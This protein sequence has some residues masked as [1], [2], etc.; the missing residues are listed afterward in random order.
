MRLLV[1]A[2]TGEA[3]A[4]CQRLAGDARVEVLASLAGETR[5]P[6]DLG[7]AVRRGGFGGGIAQE[8]FILDNEISAVIDATH[9]FAERISHRTHAICARLGLPCLRLIRPGW[10]AEDG[11]TWTVAGG[12]QWGSGR[13]GGTVRV[14]CGAGGEGLAGVV[15]VAGRGGVCGVID[16]REG[17]FR[18][19]GGGFVV[20]RPPFTVEGEV[21]LFTREGVDVLV[22]KDA[23]GEAGKAKLLAAR[24]LGIQVILIRRPPLPPG[25]RTGTVAGALDWLEGLL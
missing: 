13:V 22:A 17:P 11:G 25:A 15:N 23:G 14:F 18:L 20:G 10:Q 6:A 4:L 24:R 1:M 3:R 2:G 16:R 19:R 21:R 7:V 5:V 12:R 8:K 9:P